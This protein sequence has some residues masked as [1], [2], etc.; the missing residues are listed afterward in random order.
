ML[1]VFLS[2]SMAAFSPCQVEAGIPVQGMSY[3]GEPATPSEYTVGNTTYHFGTGEDLVLDSV[4]IA[5]GGVSYT[6]DPLGIADHIKVN[7]VESNLTGENAAGV[8]GNRL[9]FQYEGADHGSDV[10]LKPSQLYSM[11]E[12]FET[13]RVNAGAGDLFCNEGIQ[14]NNIE[15]V[16]FI[17]KDGLI[18]PPTPEGLELVGY[19]TSE[20]LGNNPY[21]V[22]AITKIGP[23]NEPLEFLP[24]AFGDTHQ[25]GPMLYLPEPG[26]VMLRT[27]TDSR[28]PT[29]KPSRYFS[30][31]QGWHGQ[32]NSLAELGLNPG[33]KFFGIALFHQDVND[34]MDLVGLSDVPLDSSDNGFDCG[35]HFGPT[36]LLVSPAPFGKIGDLV[37]NDLNKNGTQE[38]GET[39]IA[40][41][42][43][44][45]VAD[46]NGNGLV[47][48]TDL[49]VATTTT[50]GEGHY[51]FDNLFPGH[52]LV[53]VSDRDKV[54]ENHLLVS[55]DLLTVADL[56]SGGE[57]DTIDIGFREDVQ[58]GLAKQLLNLSHVQ[59]GVYDVSMRF[60][61]ENLNPKVDA[62]NIQLQ[63]DL[64]TTFAG[65]DS[66][67]VVSAP[68]ISGGLSEVSPSFIGDSADGAK[69]ENLNL[70]SGTETL[71]K[72]E[73][74]TVDLVVRVDL[75][76]ANGPFSNQAVMI[77][78]V[79]PGGLIYDQD[80]SDDGISSVATPG[81][82]PSGPGV[83]DP[84]PIPLVAEP[85]IALAKEASEVENLK[86]GTL[87]TT[88][89]FLVRNIGNTPLYDVQVDDDLARNFGTPV[90]PEG[91]TGP[92][93]YSVSFPQATAGPL[94]MNAAFDGKAVLGMIDLAAG[95]VLK[96][97]EQVLFDLTVRF[98]P[99]PSVPVPY[100]NQALAK[101]DLDEH[102][103]GIAQGD[104]TDLSDN[105]VNSFVPSAVEEDDPTPVPFAQTATIG[106]AKSV[107]EISIDSYPELVAK[108]TFLV[109]NLGSQKLEDV[110]VVDDLQQTFPAASAELL[111]VEAL[112][113]TGNLSVNPAFDGTGDTQL[114]QAGSTLEVGEKQ[115]ITFEAHFSLKQKE[116]VELTN[117][118]LATAHL[119]DGTP[120]ED[121]SDNGLE[122]DA[123]GDLN[124]NEEGENDP[125]PLGVPDIPEIIS[126]GKAA[127]R[128]EVSAGDV[129]T[130]TL[131]IQNNISNDIQGLEI[132]DRAPPGFNYKD[133]STRIIRAGAD[134][135]LYTADDIVTRTD[136][137]ITGR[138]NM[139]FPAFDIG[140]NEKLAIRYVMQVT[141]GVTEG[142]YFNRA[143]IEDAEDIVISNVVAAG[144]RVVQDALLE[145]TTIIGKVF[146]DRDGD[147]H[148]DIAD[149]TGVRLVSPQFEG[150]ERL[151]GDIKGRVRDSDPL[152]EH[153][154]VLRIPH[155]AFVLKTNEGTAL[156]VD[157]HG[158]VTEE[159]TG[160]AAKGFNNQQFTVKFTHDG[161]DPVVTITNVGISEE[162]IPG[163]RLATVDGLLIETDLYGRYHIADVSTGREDR[164]GNYIVKVDPATLPTGTE[165]T[166]ENPRVLRLGKSLMTRFNFGVKLPEPKVATYKKQVPT[167]K[168]VREKVDLT[169]LMPDVYFDSG[170]D[171]LRPDAQ[172]MLNAIVNTL[173]G[174][175]NIEL[176]VIGHTDSQRLSKPTQYNFGTNYGLGQARADQVAAYLRHNLGLNDQNSKSYT[177]GETHPIASN[178]TPDGMQKNRRAEINPQYEEVKLKEVMSEKTVRI[179]HGGVVWATEDPLKIDPRLSVRADGALVINE[180]GE[181]EPLTF[182]TYSNYGA[183][184]TGWVLEIYDE[185]DVDQL[186]P[187][188]KISGSQLSN[189][190]AIEWNGN[191]DGSIKPREG[192]KLNYRLRVLDG[193]GHFDETYLS[194][195]PV[196][197]QRLQNKFNR[198]FAKTSTQGSTET[199]AEANA[200]AGTQTLPGN[201]LA[202]QGINQLARQTIPLRGS[203][204]RI[205]GADLHHDYR[206][207]I[208]GEP[209]KVDTDNRFVIEQ[210][211]PVGQH[212]FTLHVSNAQGLD[213]TRK[214]GIEV[215]G[216]YLFMVGL[217]N[218][219]VGKNTVSGHVEP[220]NGDEHY[221]ESTFVDGRAAFYLKGKIKGKY[222]VTAQLDT[223]EDQ[224][225]HLG[226]RLKDK[227][228][229]QLFRKLDPDQ[230]YPVYGDGST[231][232]S[233]VDTQGAFYVRVEW[234]KS[235]AKWGNF[236]SGIT[237]NEFA[238][239]DRTLYG[240]QLISRT[241][242]LT[243]W[244]DHKTQINAFAS[245]AQ[246][247]MAH[248]R[249]R[250]TGGSLYYLREQDVVRGSEKLW[251]EVRERD[252]ERVIETIAYEP[253]KDYQ[254]DYLQGRII[255][256]R[257][258]SQVSSSASG[259]L[260]SD[261]SL[262][263]NPVYLMADYEYVPDSFTGSELAAGFRGKHWLNDAVAIGAT[264]IHE[265]RDAASQDYALK[266]VDLT[267]KGGK[268]TWM[269]VELADSDASQSQSGWLSANGGLS[270]DRIQSETSS[271]RSGNAV[272]VEGQINLAEISAGDVQGKAIAWWKDRE[273]GFSTARSDDGLA[274]LDRGVE[275]AW[276]AN[277]VLR[278]TTRATSLEKSSDTQTQTKDVASVQAK[279][280]T[281][282]RLDLLAEV[283]HEN[284]ASRDSAS[285]SSTSSEATLGAVGL[286]Y[287]L[288]DH[289]DVTASAQTVLE[290]NGNYQANDRVTVGVRDQ[291]TDRLALK[292]EV[293]TGD[294]GDAITVGGSYQVNDQLNVQLQAGAGDGATSEIGSR[295]LTSDGTE[296]YGSYA[297][298]PDRDDE[299]KKTVTLGQRKRLG[300]ATNLFV[301]ERF[302]ENKQEAGV[303]HV[304]GIEHRVS[305]RVSVNGGVQHSTLEDTSGETLKRD[306]ASAGLSYR[307]RGIKASTRLE[308]RQ[309]QS[310]TAGGD[311]SANTTQ[312]LTAN[313]VDWQANPHLKWLIRLNFSI[314]EN[315][316][317]G[318]TEAQFLEGDLGFAYRPAF[319][320]R[321]NVLGKYSRLI[322]LPSLGQDTVR[323][324]EKA[325]VIAL[326]AL[327]DLSQKW[328]VGGKLAWRKGEVRE[329]REGDDWF[330]SGARLAILRSR[331][332]FIKR[333]DALAEY[334]VLEAE[335]GD[336]RKH[337]GLLGLYRQVGRNFKVGIGYN[338]T[339]FD[340]DLKHLDYDAEGWFIDMVGKF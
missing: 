144:V 78:Y 210:Q 224:I 65:V 41:V 292:G 153:Q 61:L 192:D 110:Q 252:T 6:M 282:E 332:H 283:R 11:E 20:R 309:D 139:A 83:D 230:F 86:D 209:V 18:A 113:A 254:I 201:A 50:D 71:K 329:Q 202:L 225:K 48:A 9:Y 298:N 187:L 205:H 319:T 199:N 232:L 305:K 274:T 133:G 1:G 275:L 299:S 135:K 98:V 272:S 75:G 316:V 151:L 324:D 91:L 176:N 96:P 138:A 158:N 68:V 157:R 258:L 289:A 245:E 142:D 124:P 317:S 228:P 82:D 323:A 24:L 105:G 149:A 212:E 140:A 45:L 186:K 310:Q 220:L 90:T 277:S 256:N 188:A 215:R 108:F 331:Y 190:R 107:G 193:Q 2:V 211:L 28:D 226:D 19:V 121:L 195:L 128:A 238:Q 236:H 293:S 172:W 340:D 119:L 93:T 218:L 255:L 242:D 130:Y 49:T 54:L 70:L 23:N 162:G 80:L 271:K 29:L 17:V 123:D 267:L 288:N 297:V 97:D 307:D 328:E 117:Q 330:D 183:Y 21:K 104:T 229:Q 325:H 7:R 137:V 243:R 291:V 132:I 207:T 259:S 322:D 129:L 88:F 320:D 143:F 208:N 244:G 38:E 263:G 206:L 92:G 66:F 273:A 308:Y 165:F 79:T 216:E 174:K 253:G 146:H 235:E 251:V 4:S 152:D 12:I 270:F 333:W 185:H 95:G 247:A 120:T 239:Y 40:G 338:Y 87:E 81:G 126:L 213:W 99:D 155:H 177:W 326:E 286:K 279:V 217:A 265:N 314:T 198:R 112:Q 56:P 46:L 111:R 248:N 141:T 312:W 303:G 13:A 53:Q 234:D 249:F 5:I 166:T 59:G 214:L 180:S 37:W 10:Y 134:G 118:G 178:K 114:L 43:L 116:G 159:N 334:R 72:G 22:A 156:K 222:L 200:Q 203:R 77:S 27:P 85:R 35:D 296:L 315:D 204:V 221:D 30:V 261:Q 304:F 125:T 115:T 169:G 240:A 16:D 260:I 306:T 148:Q 44:D 64:A 58:I 290:D 62:P 94:T 52:Y 219:T 295:Y 14:P 167:K 76:D 182:H 154:V 31:Q 287:R 168:I 42:T 300:D 284:I 25:Y 285:N 33:Q 170:K 34:G 147:G 150:G 8:K 262:D 67:E 36:G 57:L 264:Y 103:D 184:I 3:H 55:G 233:D 197:D 241:T 122:P 266:G 196:I 26:Q 74:A 294:R 257:P 32:F 276:Q 47:D 15:R 127:S 109:E 311:N 131:S 194:D 223:T 175:E 227:N 164:G 136:P 191:I 250:A 60:T 313:A 337:G 171:I 69:P 173:R 246:T 181:V 101:G 281:T 160:E 339:E 161:F 63:D 145:K 318:L 89:T 163:V 73:T 39:G 268:G 231:T 102:A 51:S 189:T 100:L 237:G 278:L 335:S 280:R 301:E 84:T 269:K 336:D 327:Y 106:L 179:P 302:T 321:L